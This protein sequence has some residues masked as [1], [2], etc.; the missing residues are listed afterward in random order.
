MLRLGAMIDLD[1]TYRRLAHRWTQQQLASRYRDAERQGASDEDAAAEELSRPIT[2]VAAAIPP[3]ASMSVAVHV[4][5]VLPKSARDGLSGKL[6]ATAERNAADALGRCHRALELDGQTQD[7]T[8]GEWL[9]VVYEIAAELLES[10]RPEADPPTLVK[11]AQDAI[12]WLSRAVIE[13]DQGSAEVAETLAEALARLLAVS[14]FAAEAGR[15]QT[16]SA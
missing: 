11:A 16:A 2:L 8:A 13:L 3:S 10:A 1:D 12:G 15:S 6:V 5:H 4:L 9:P 7:Y 14:V